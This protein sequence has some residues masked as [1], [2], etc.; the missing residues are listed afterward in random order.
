MKTALSLLCVLFTVTCQAQ[1]V[2]PVFGEIDLPSM[3]LEK[4]SFEPEANAM[5]LFDVQDLEYEF[6]AIGGKTHKKRRVRIKIFNEK[7]LDAASVRIPFFNK[8]K[9]TQVSELRGLVY[10]LSPEGA[11]QKK[12]IPEEDF[13]RNK[14]NAAHETISFAFPAVKPGDVI[15]YTYSV[16]EKNSQQFQPWIIQ[17]EIPCEYISTVITIPSFSH[18]SSFY[19]GRDSVDQKKET[20]GK[21]GKEKRIQTF[22]KSN[23]SSF[24]PEPYM[25]SL[26]DNLAR[27]Y[28]VLFTE[29]DEEIDAIIESNFVWKSMGDLML[30]SNTFKWQSVKEIPGT[31]PYVDTARRFS[32]TKERVKYLFEVVKN[33]M[34]RTAQSFFPEDIAGAWKDK[35]GTSAEIN[36]ILFNLL[37]QVDVVCNP[38]LFSTRDNGRVQINF[39]SISQLNGLNIMVV[40]VNAFYVLD[41]SS[42]NQSYHTPPPNILER[43]ALILEPGGVRWMFVSDSRTLSQ[44][45]QDL[46]LWFNDKKELEGKSINRFYNYARQYRL[47]KLDKDNLSE[48]PKSEIPAGITVTSFDRYDDKADSSPLEETTHFTFTP[49]STDDY[50]FINPLF[51]SPET[52]NPFITEKRQSDIDFGSKQEIRVGLKLEIPEGYEVESMP[53]PLV[54]KNSDSSF[55]FKRMTN[56]D[57]QNVYFSQTFEIRQSRFKAEEYADIREFY[58]FIAGKMSEEII[59]RKKKKE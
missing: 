31:E 4:C 14:V 48:K 42:K 38:I 5:V 19:M 41:A 35:R 1:R 50:Y 59:L 37:R 28:F 54:A 49:N 9:T 12:E 32:T 56:A 3:K 55:V 33:E 40:D 20:T 39:P 27:M 45:S 52:R 11:I 51:F 17:R 8:K 30:K 46:M 22:Y 24:L 36:M 25:S 21:G 10:S 7:G 44:T 2:V 53:A 16:T 29:G 13:Y 23:V 34:V 26:Q 43:D 6:S 15:E 18:L 58:K 47:D 57:A